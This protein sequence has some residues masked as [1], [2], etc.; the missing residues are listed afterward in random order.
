MDAKTDINELIIIYPNMRYDLSTVLEVVS[1]WKVPNI[2]IYAI[3]DFDVNY[4]QNEKK[5]IGMPHGLEKLQIVLRRKLKKLGAIIDTTTEGS[6][7]GDLENPE[8]DSSES[9]SSGYDPDSWTIKFSLPSTSKD[10]K[11]EKASKTKNNKKNEPTEPP[12]T[13]FTLTY[14][15]LDPFGDLWPDMDDA[16]ILIHT[17]GPLDPDIIAEFVDNPYLYGTQDML[18]TIWKA[19]FLEPINE[20]SNIYFYGPVDEY[21]D[22]STSDE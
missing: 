20:G 15:D 2:S 8:S 7:P 10:S 14:Y 21:F 9:D 1:L 11:T 5:P 17:N 6:D 18:K 13:K 12:M 16:H 22:T 4:L 19:D 3:D